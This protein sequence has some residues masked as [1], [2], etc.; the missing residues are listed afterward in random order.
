MRQ[1]GLG[2]ESLSI[3]VPPDQVLGPILLSARDPA[4]PIPGPNGRWDP[5]APAFSSCQ[6]LQKLK[7]RKLTLPDFILVD[8]TG[9]EPAAS[10]V[11]VR[12][13]TK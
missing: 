2:H 11:Q 10:S 13:S 5:A 7:T 6:V 4:S 8:L 3:I 9:F 1:E 12:R